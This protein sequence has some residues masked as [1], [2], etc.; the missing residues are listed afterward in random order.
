[1]RFGNR[2]WAV[3]AGLALALPALAGDHKVD[4]DKKGQTIAKR[5]DNLKPGDTL[6]VSGTCREFVAVTPEM[7]RIT[8][9]GQGTASIE[10][11]DDSRNAVDI[12]GTGITVTG[13]TITGGFNGVSVRQGG[14]ALIAGNLIQGS[15]RD[16]LIV[17]ENASASVT[18]NTIRNHPRFGVLVTESS[19]ARLGILNLAVDER[20]VGGVGP[21]T[22]EQNGADGVQVL[23]SSS[24][25]L[26]QNR[27]AGNGRH[28]VVVVQHAHALIAGNAL[29]ANAQDGILVGET[30]GVNL[31]TG[32]SPAPEDQVNSTAGNNGGFGIRCFVYS[33]ARGAQ[34]TLNGAAGPKSFTPICFDGVTP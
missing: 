7:E 14:R 13:F 11:P 32:A 31:G 8:L 21:N 25:V 18:N 17:I 23:R 5:L 30:S 3:A 19:S 20:P 2:C 34:G 15:A 29:D 12:R 6:R 24:A 9:E 16:G 33:Y 1:M 4:C 28:G 22:I 10:A 26:V 27:I